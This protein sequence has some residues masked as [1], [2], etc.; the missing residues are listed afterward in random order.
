MGFGGHNS[1]EVTLLTRYH[2]IVSVT[3]L[4]LLILGSDWYPSVS[5]ATNP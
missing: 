3:N 4:E 2:L 5:L 1:R